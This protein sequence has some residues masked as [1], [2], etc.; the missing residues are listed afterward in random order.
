MVM[1]AGNL[2]FSPAF[3]KLKT[4]LQAAREK[5]SALV[6]EYTCFISV[7][8]RNLEAEYMLKL[9]KKE[10]ELFSCQVEILRLKREI[11]LFQAAR[12]RG[13]SI[14]EQEVRAVITREFEEYRQQLE[15]Q[16][17]KLKAAEEHFIAPKLTAEESAGLKKLYHNI[18]R[19]LHPDLNPDLPA[20]AA[21]LWERVQNAYQM[22][23][24][25]ELSLL[26]DMVDEMLDGKGDYVDS[27]NTMEHLEMEM[28]KILQKTAELTAQFARTRERIPFAYEKILSN[29][30]AVTFRRRELDE[31]IRIC[32]EHIAELKEI[33]ARF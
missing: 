2:A 13:E 3:E 18:V 15:E 21:A 32:R 25:N 14:T 26:A 6:E 10:H 11:A 1:P 8:G 31:D 27:I 7:A 9:G 23:D 28:E 24:W 20:G 29:P 5:Y 12:N 22:N 19:K 16:Q 4:D 33:K 17:Q 30:A